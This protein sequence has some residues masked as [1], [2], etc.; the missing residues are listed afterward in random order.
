[1]EALDDSGSEKKSEEIKGAALIELSSK[2]KNDIA[3]T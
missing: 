1:L 3:V 2:K